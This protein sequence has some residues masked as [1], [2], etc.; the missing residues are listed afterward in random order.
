MIYN[1]R[2]GGQSYTSKERADNFVRRGIAIM[3]GAMLRFV[4]QIPEP[5]RPAPAMR[6]DEGPTAWWNGTD[7]DP[8]AMHR[9]GEVRS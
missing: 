5:I 3:D 7:P 9:P 4:R 1:P 6:D 2:P 8:C